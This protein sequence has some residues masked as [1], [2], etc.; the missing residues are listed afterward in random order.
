MVHFKDISKL[1]ISLLHRLYLSIL[2]AGQTFWEIHTFAIFETK[3]TR[4][5]LSNV[6]TVNIKLEP[7]DG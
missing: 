6:S 2:K 7:G 3:M 4:S 1:E 5:I